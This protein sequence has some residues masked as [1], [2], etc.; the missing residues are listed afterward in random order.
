MKKLQ[1]I[2]DR[3]DY[4]KATKNLKLLNETDLYINGRNYWIQ[5]QKASGFSTSYLVVD[6]RSLETERSFFYGND[7][8]C[9]VS[10]A[11]NKDFVKFANDLQTFIAM[12]D[13]LQTE[14]TKAAQCTEFFT[15]YKDWKS[16][17]NT[18]KQTQELD[19]KEERL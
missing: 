3:T 14:K 17:Q 7:F 12:L 9:R 6:G 10:D 4:V 5:T 11:K 13:I 1:E 16:F 2:A 18:K 19:K 8:N 15:F